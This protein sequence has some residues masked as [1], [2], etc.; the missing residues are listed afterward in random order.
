MVM[1]FSLALALDPR[2]IRT[3]TF[4]PFIWRWFGHQA[5]HRWAG[6]SAGSSL[7]WAALSEV[8][9]CTLWTAILSEAAVQRLQGGFKMKFQSRDRP[10]IPGLDDVEIQKL[11]RG[12]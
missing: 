11:Q 8:P 1:L 2:T 12:I 3:G 4:W 6:G 10:H 7:P 9:L 5:I